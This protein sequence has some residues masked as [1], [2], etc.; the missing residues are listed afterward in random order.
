[1]LRDPNYDVKLTPVSTWLACKALE[2]RILYRAW[3]SARN[4]AAHHRTVPCDA[5]K[6]CKLGDW[7]VAHSFY[8]T[9]SCLRETL[10][11]S[12]LARLTWS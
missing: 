7:V 8:A 3:C 9:E 5:C 11:E 1:M 6:E 10:F 2:T 12:V 4:E